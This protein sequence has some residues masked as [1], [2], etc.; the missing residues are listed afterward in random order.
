[1]LDEDV[2]KTRLAQQ[3]LD[4]KMEISGAWAIAANVFVSRARETNER[5]WTFIFYHDSK[6]TAFRDL[7]LMNR[8]MQILMA[9]FEQGKLS[10]DAADTLQIF[11]FGG[12]LAGCPVGYEDNAINFAS[13]ILI[14]MDQSEILW[15]EKAQSIQIDK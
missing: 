14:S 8:K 4:F 9:G 11:Y 3:L 2:F 13:H 10:E 15:F 7:Q 5:D 1:M 12:V 6:E